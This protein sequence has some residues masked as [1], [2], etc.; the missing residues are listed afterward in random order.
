MKGEGKSVKG[1]AK[2]VTPG[3]ERRNREERALRHTFVSLLKGW[4]DEGRSVRNS[5]C[6]ARGRHLWHARGR[7]NL[8]TEM[9]AYATWVCREV[10]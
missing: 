6:E 9:R 4:V 3:A 8:C 1:R 2:S 7:I 10:Q 5:T